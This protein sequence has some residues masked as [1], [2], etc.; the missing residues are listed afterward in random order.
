MTYSTHFQ[1]KQ[2][3]MTVLKVLLSWNQQQQLFNI[4]NNIVLLNTILVLA[5]LNCTHFLNNYK[6]MKLK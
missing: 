1:N 6:K 2:T 5:Q 3:K 4:F